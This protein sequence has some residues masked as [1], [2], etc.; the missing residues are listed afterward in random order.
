M[1]KDVDYAHCFTCK[2]FRKK[3]NDSV[4]ERPIELRVDEL[5]PRIKW[6]TAGLHVMADMLL[7][8]DKGGFTDA[9]ESVL[10]MWDELQEKFSLA[11]EMLMFDCSCPVDDALKHCNSNNQEDIKKRR[12]ERKSK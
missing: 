7:K 9:S 10:D 12:E 3:G 11:W 8:K 6:L 5:R 1:N 2:Y 4:C